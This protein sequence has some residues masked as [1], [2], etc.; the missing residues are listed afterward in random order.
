MATITT[1]DLWMIH[2]VSLGVA[3]GI[4]VPLS[5]GSVFLRNHINVLKSNG[6]WLRVHLWLATLV[7][8]LTGVGYGVAII[9]EERDEDGEFEENEVFDDDA[10]S[11]VGIIVLIMV[12]LQVIMGFIRP[13]PAVIP[14]SPSTGEK[15][16]GIFEDEEYHDAEDSS[17]EM[18]PAAAENET[19]TSST[20]PKM[21]TIRKIW[22]FTHRLFGILLL[23]LA[24][25]NCH[26]GI[27][28]FAEYYG[29]IDYL[30]RLFWGI[31][32]SLSGIIVSVGCAL[33]MLA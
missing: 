30:L 10:H 14:V 27:F 23:G 19:D 29:P 26:S 15:K 22:E 20:K 1:R 21:C 13:K 11:F 3:W 33:K 32:G 2:G 8:V 9:A 5:I 18:E 4:L 6:R 24:W 28:L 25:F 16:E 12:F 31:T 7:A 17:N